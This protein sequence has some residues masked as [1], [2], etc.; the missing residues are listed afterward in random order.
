MPRCAALEKC[1]DPENPNLLCRSLAG[2]SPIT[3]SESLHARPITSLPRGSSPTPL[4]RPP[5]PIDQMRARRNV[6]G[7]LELAAS[8]ASLPRLLMLLLPPRS[9]TLGSRRTDATA[10]RWHGGARWSRSSPSCS[11]SRRACPAGRG[12]RCT[13]TARNTASSGGRVSTHPKSCL[14]AASR[15]TLLV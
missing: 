12:D 6:T 13:C 5:F 8:C 11:G 7:D 14:A 2:A 10:P 4:N 9:R 1:W 15:L 3:S